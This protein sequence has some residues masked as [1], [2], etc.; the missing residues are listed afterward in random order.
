MFKKLKIVHRL[1]FAFLSLGALVLII[2]SIV[3]YFQF[4]EALIERTL[5]QLSSVNMLKKTALE[6]AIEAKKK[7]LL[8]YAKSNDMVV[9][10]KSAKELGLTECDAKIFPD[11]LSKIGKALVLDAT[12]FMKSD[13]LTLAFLIPSKKGMF[14]FTEIPDYVEKSVHE[15]TGM[16]AT[17]ESYIVGYDLLMRTRSRFFPDKN[18]LSITVNT[19][20]VTLAIAGQEGRSIIKD[21]RDVSVLSAY[22]KINIDGL[23][24]ILLSEIDEEEAIY[25]VEIMRNRLF[26]ISAVFLLLIV[27]LSIFISNRIAIPIKK[28]ENV[29]LQLAKGSLPKKLPPTS[30]DEIGKMASAIEELVKGLEKSIVFA[31]KIGQ[32]DFEVQHQLLSEEDAL[33]KAMEAMRNRLKEL[34]QKNEELSL[35]SKS[36]LIQGQEEERTRLSQDIHDGVGPL[37]TSI[38]LQLGELKIEEEE[39]NRLKTLIDDTITEMRRVSYNLMPSVLLDFGAGA[40]IKNML[41]ALSKSKKYNIVYL[42]DTKKSA[43]KLNKEINVA[44]YRIAQETVNNAIKHASATEIKISLTEFDD[45]VCFFIADNGI[46][47][48]DKQSRNDFSGKGLKNISE[49]AALLNGEIFITSDGQ[50]TSIEVEIPL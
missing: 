38:K 3:F 49:R 10:R 16:G 9:L 47:F 17:G 28:L 35:Q 22:R 39:K 30:G 18:P 13:S 2:V 26:V 14:V 1:T 31:D 50:G 24:W 43:S 45:K 41:E 7:R 25:S 5:E 6:E 8:F 4:K 42:D 11:S 32:G 21:Y 44:L 15:R 12:T 37:L 29:V 48:K 20:G 40:A 34:V 36:A 33:G 46:G 19:K 27:I 23:N